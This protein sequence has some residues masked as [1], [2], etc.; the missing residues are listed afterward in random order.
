MLA[1]GV[2]SERGVATADPTTTADLLLVEL[3][4]RVV[5]GLHTVLEVQGIHV[6]G[7]QG[8]WVQLAPFGQPNLGFVLHLAP[9]ATIVEAVAALQAWAGIPPADRPRLV[10]VGA[11][12]E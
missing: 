7:G 11:S 10:Q 3:D 4:H 9:T 1:S 6:L 12:D 5:K 8:T 2:Y